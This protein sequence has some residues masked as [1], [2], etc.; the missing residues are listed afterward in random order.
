MKKL[1]PKAKAAATTAVTTRLHG[2]S[3]AS[4]VDKKDVQSSRV[5]G[6]TRVVHGSPSEAATFTAPCYKRSLKGREIRLLRLCPEEP[7]DQ[8]FVRFRELSDGSTSRVDV[9]RC[10]LKV[11]S[12]DD[13][14][15][16]HAL[17]YVW[18]TP[19][20]RE[21]VICNGSQVSVSWNL[22]R[23][24]SF[25]CKQSLQHN[26]PSGVGKPSN[27]PNKDELHPVWK[28]EYWWVDAICINQEDIS[29]RDSQ[30]RMMGDI[31]GNARRTLI[32]LGQE[33]PQMT[34]SLR[35]LVNFIRSFQ[36]TEQNPP[37][38]VQRLHADAGSA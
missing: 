11:V 15:L 19:P 17:S 37:R 34:R 29:E 1:L 10:E 2:D 33:S 23:F 35:D 7:S 21:D 26:L 28:Q 8:F 14:P 27:E 24:L 25:L 32:W 5:G 6:S 36:A 16:Y 31:F 38:D 20:G 13:N 12:L 30:V 22:Y 18:G 9:L 4:Q 3:I